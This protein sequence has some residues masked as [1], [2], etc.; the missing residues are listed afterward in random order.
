MSVKEK[1]GLGAVACVLGMAVAGMSTAV[2]AD[3]AGA[4]HRRGSGNQ[5]GGQHAGIRP[6]PSRNRHTMPASRLHSLSPRRPAQKSPEQRIAELDKL[7]AGGYITPEEYK[8]KKKAIV[9]GM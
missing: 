9:D 3:G 8:R 1:M 4:F 5:G 6:R 2:L 7:A